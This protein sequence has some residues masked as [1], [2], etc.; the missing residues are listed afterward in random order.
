MEEKAKIRNRKLLK[1][2][3]LQKKGTASKILLLRWGAEMLQPNI[4][5]D[6]SA[7]FLKNNTCSLAN[8]NSPVS[9]AYED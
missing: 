6:Y 9:F 3:A 4:G 7:Q 8:Y 5:S 2:L 1:T